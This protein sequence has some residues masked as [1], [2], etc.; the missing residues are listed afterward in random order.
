MRSAMSRT[1]VGPWSSSW[2]ANDSNARQAL[3]EERGSSPGDHHTL[4]TPELTSRFDFFLVGTTNLAG[5]NSYEL[6][7]QPKCPPLPVHHM[8]DKLLNNLSGTIWIDANEY[9]LARADIHL[10]SQVEF[11]G[12]LIGSLK[13]LNYSISRARAVDGLWLNSITTGLFEGRK[14][15]DS[16]HFRTRSEITNIQVQTR[17]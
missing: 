10:N 1:D 8:V 6:K 4:L 12:G 17:Q 15:V 11:W 14:L 9:E 16:K 5:R 7:F 13:S 3:G 2:T